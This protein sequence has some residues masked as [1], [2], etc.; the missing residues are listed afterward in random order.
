MLSASEL[1]RATFRRSPE[2]FVVDELPAYAPSGQGEH[3]YVTFR[4]VDLTTPEAVKRLA[5]ALGAD[6]RAAGYA[7][8]KDR[9]A[10]TTQT[11][12]F[13]IPLVKDPLPLL[14]APLEGI[15]ILGAARHINKLKPGHLLGNRFRIV[16]RDLDPAAVPALI[17]ALD[18]IGRAGVPNAFGPQRFG[19]DGAN[20]ERALEWLAGKSRGPRDKRDQRMLFSAL[21]SLWFNQVLE[22]RE[23]AGT[24]AAVLPGDLAKKTD[25]GG[26]FLVPLEGPE[27]DEARARAKSGEIMATGPMFGKKMRWP[28]GEPATI[29]RD[30][31]RAAIEDPARLDAWGHLG[32]GTRRPLRMEV[33]E[34]ACE[35]LI[36]GA[37][38][39][40]AVAVT[41]V[42]PKGG[43]ATTVLGRAVQLDDATNSRSTREQTAEAERLPQDESTSH[44]E[45]SGNG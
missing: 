4:K 36:T 12:S 6:P 19:R 10:V 44:E 29:E 15:E 32:E 38:E 43:Y 45:D 9:H 21:Q 35:P 37:D 41:F 26:L 2:D 18:A 30:V 27:S 24:W 20:P 16:L 11:A 34:L 13:Q 7:G 1:P 5:R 31:L 39:G 23:Q 14:A 17:A 3:L 33:S 8:M 40:A 22:R 28:E 42:L 25:T